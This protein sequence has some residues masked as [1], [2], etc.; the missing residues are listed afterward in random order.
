M[1]PAETSLSKSVKNN[2]VGI[3]RIKIRHNYRNTTRIACLAG[4]NVGSLLT[5]TPVVILKM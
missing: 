5:G 2:Q 3:W 1:K 4:A